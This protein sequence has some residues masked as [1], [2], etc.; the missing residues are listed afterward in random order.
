MDRRLYMVLPI[1][2]FSSPHEVFS[3]IYLTKAQKMRF[4]QKCLPLCDGDV[5]D[6][7]LQKALLSSPSRLP[8]G[9]WVEGE[10]ILFMNQNPFVKSV[11]HQA[12]LIRRPSS[13]DRDTV[14]LLASNFPRL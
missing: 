3:T 2:S 9:G 12:P 14:W 10:S 7:Q 4:W 6:A 5:E 8:P 13:A 11:D 1:C